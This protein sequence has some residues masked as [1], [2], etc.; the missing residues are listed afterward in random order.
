LC[1]D[2]TVEQLVAK[3]TSHHLEVLNEVYSKVSEHA[4]PAIED[5]INASVKGREKAVE[6]KGA[7]ISEIIEIEEKVRIEQPEIPETGRKEHHKYL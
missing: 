7:D 2:T 1:K 5:A 6:L 4:K 3:A